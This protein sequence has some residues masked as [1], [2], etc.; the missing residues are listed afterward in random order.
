MIFQAFNING[1]Y[2]PNLMAV[3][4]FANIFFKLL[5]KVEKF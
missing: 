1:H 5:A 2:V 4:R 3:I